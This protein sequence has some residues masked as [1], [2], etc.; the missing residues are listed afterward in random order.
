MRHQPPRAILGRM[1]RPARVMGSKP[2]FEIAGD[3]DVALVLNCEIFDEVDAFHESIP[4][5]TPRKLCFGGQPFL[6]PPWLA[7]RSFSEGWWR[8]GELNP[9]P[10]RCER[11]A[12]PTE[13]APHWT[14]IQPVRRRPHVRRIIH[15]RFLSLYRKF[16]P[17]HRYDRSRGSDTCTTDAGA[18]A[19]WDHARFLDSC[20]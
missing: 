20:R 8:A 14:D 16:D 12:L 3:A 17:P 1:R 4:L 19:S 11:S 15:N 5:R 9:R 2:C 10:L 7:S 6:K 18:F 13:L